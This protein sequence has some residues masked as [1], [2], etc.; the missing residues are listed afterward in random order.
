MEAGK[1]YKIRIRLSATDQ[2][3]DELTVASVRPV[4]AGSGLTEL[5]VSE[6]FRSGSTP[7]K[8]DL[9]AFGESETYAKPFRIIS[10]TRDTDLKRRITALEYINEIYEDA[11]VIPELNYTTTPGVSNVKISEH[12]DVS[13]KQYI[14][15]FWTPPRLNYYGARV[16]LD[17]Q[18]MAQ[19]DATQCSTSIEFNQIKTYDIKISTLDYFGNDV[20]AVAETYS[21]H[22]EPRPENIRGLTNYFNGGTMMLTW[23]AIEDSRSIIYEVR[24]GE[25]WDTAQYLGRT[26]TPGFI[27][28]G[29]GWYW[30]A[31][32]YRNLYSAEPK[33]IYIVGSVISA[34]NIYIAY[35][36]EKSG[37]PG[38][39]SEGAVK[40][41]DMI[42]LAG[43][44]MFDEI[45]DF[46]EL[47]NLDFYGDIQPRGIYTIP[48]NRIIDI[49]EE[50]LVTITAAIELDTDSAPGFVG[51]EMAFAN[52]VIE[53][54]IDPDGKGFDDW[55][56]FTPGQYN[57]RVFNF[58]VVLTSTNPSVTPKLTKFSYTVD[59][60]DKLDR[61]Q[62]KI[63]ESGSWVPFNVNFHVPPQV[64]ITELDAQSGD[65]LVL[66]K[67]SI[68]TTKFWVQVLN[69][70]KAG[71]ERSINWLAKGY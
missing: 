6:P 60:V 35:D 52:A 9:Y 53:I 67:V 41:G 63:D 54:Q 44:N 59:M 33:P 22:G 64:Q 68:D 18:K 2:L 45:T 50:E 14:D 56:T 66:S 43:T 29:D 51:D 46:D 5:T 31:G 30:V 28:Q 70:N 57:G 19:L 21:A 55:Q 40:C 11:P 27:G 34:N 62:V 25:D 1:A 10:I 49:G 26:L 42:K 36:E 16:E 8:D 61:G 37:W 32:Y 69:E 13:G 17:G 65:T 38:T 15:I 3:L 48:E 71:A 12:I 20:A 7:N 58:R 4:T 24:K 39:V 47:S 23:Q